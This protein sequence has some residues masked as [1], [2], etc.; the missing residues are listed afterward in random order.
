MSAVKHNR[1]RRSKNSNN[2]NILWYFMIKCDNMNESAT[3]LGIWLKDPHMFSP[4]LCKFFFFDSSHYSKY[5]KALS[6]F[7]THLF[8]KK[9]DDGRGYRAIFHHTLWKQPATVFPR[10][11]KVHSFARWKQKAPNLTS[12]SHPHSLSP[13][14]Y[15]DP[16]LEEQSHSLHH[17]SFLEI[18]LL[19]ALALH[20][21][22]RKQTPL[23][24]DFHKK[25]K[26]KTKQQ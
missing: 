10:D 2:T 7:L 5:P 15:V 20:K 8:L 17:H 22:E 11:A 21:L 9:M 26:K 24:V 14:A 16:A 25:N 23:D 4:I 13:S 19:P 12:L 18:K 3:I 6:S 1:I